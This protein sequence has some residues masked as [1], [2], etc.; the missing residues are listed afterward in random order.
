V[1]QWS[2]WRISA[3]VGARLPKD[4]R[5]EPKAQGPS[6]LF[7]SRQFASRVGLGAPPSLQTVNR[8]SPVKCVWPTLRNKGWAQKTDHAEGNDDGQDK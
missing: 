1:D 3:P 5:A 8:V 6:R 7:G 4:L 2:N